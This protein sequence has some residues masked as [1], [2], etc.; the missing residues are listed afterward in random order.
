MDLAEPHAIE[1]PRVRQLRQLER[2][3]ERRDLVDP[4][5][6]LLDEDSKMHAASL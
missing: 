1:T 3:P 5:T 6:H 2:F 4:T